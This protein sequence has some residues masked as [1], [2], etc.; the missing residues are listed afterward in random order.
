[1]KRT[2]LTALATLFFIAVTGLTFLAQQ[3][4]AQTQAQI[5]ACQSVYE[6]VRTNAQINPAVAAQKG[7]QFLQDGCGRV[8]PTLVTPVQQYI[9]WYDQQQAALPAAGQPA[10]AAVAVQ[11]TT[12]ANQ[13]D[14]GWPAPDTREMS[15][16]F[17]FVKYRYDEVNWKL[18]VTV[19][20]KADWSDRPH[21]GWVINFYD[22]DGVPVIPENGFLEQDASLNAGKVEVFRAYCPKPSEMKRVRSVVITRRPE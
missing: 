6:Q 8:Y 1:M 18:Y 4:L 2:N 5:A 19:K 12:T 17:E 13:D 9:A 10:Q 16:W 15:R 11:P 14:S 7:K 22:Q 21:N 3:G 20:T